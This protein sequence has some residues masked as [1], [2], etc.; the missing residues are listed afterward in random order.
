MSLQLHGV[1]HFHPP[2]EI[3]NAFLESLGMETTDDWIMDRVGIRSRRTGLPLDYLVQTKNRDPR[4]GIEVAEFSNA[5]MG[6]KAAE[7]AVEQTPQSGCPSN[8]MT[9]L[10][11]G[12][13]QTIVVFRSS[14]ETRRLPS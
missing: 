14:P 7:M 3:T 1:G 4:E 6:A 13:S 11:P 10:R 9:S 12:K 5:E 2:N 8:R